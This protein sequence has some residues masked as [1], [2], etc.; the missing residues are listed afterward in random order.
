MADLTIR[1]FLMFEGKAEEFS[2]RSSP[3]QEKT[4]DE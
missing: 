3:A 4:A 2:F 1:P